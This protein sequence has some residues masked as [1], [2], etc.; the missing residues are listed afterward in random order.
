F[1]PS[2]GAL[3]PVRTSSRCRGRRAGGA[4]RPAPAE[5]LPTVTVTG[6]VTGN[7]WAPTGR[8]GKEPKV[9]PTVTTP[10]PESP[11]AKRYRIIEQEAVNE[12][13][14][15]RSCSRLNRSSDSTSKNESGLTRFCSHAW[16]KR[17][18]PPSF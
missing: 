16:R 14:A 11:A 2:E 15:L 18:R 9:L 8:R 6:V 5:L 4:Y 3:R 1:G 13:L 17:A 12:P 7:A 10:P